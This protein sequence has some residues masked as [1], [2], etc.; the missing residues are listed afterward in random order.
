MCKNKGEKS[1]CPIRL[2]ALDIDGT[3]LNEA[4]EITPATIE[5]LKQIQKKG[6]HVV[7]SS[8]RDYEGLPWEQLKEVPVEYV[9]TLNGSGVYET[10]NKTCLYEQYLEQ[11][12]MISVLSF[13]LEQEVY[14][15]VFMNGTRYVPEDCF[16]YVD[17]MRLPEYMKNVLRNAKNHMEDMLGYLRTH[18][19]EIQKVALN[20]QNEPDGT[21]HNREKVKAYL[22]NCPELQVVD[23][24]FSSLEFT[25]KGITKAAGLEFLTGYLGILAE[26]TMAVG[27]S[28]NDLDM[29]AWAGIG[30]AMGNAPEHV[31]EAAFDVTGTNEEDGVA[32][33]VANY[34][35][36]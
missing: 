17:Q 23:G 5:A 15:T 28:E 32:M 35:R 9:I 29:L 2:L 30:I 13:L 11:E 3:L 19:A 20:F 27:D 26:E 6:V 8:G 14:V 25:K 31:K 24:G 34:F 16:A 1:K 12:K 10:L 22:E 36:I 33:A 18:K 4:G 21:F 7:L